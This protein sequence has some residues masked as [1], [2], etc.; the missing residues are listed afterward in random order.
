MPVVVEGA[1]NR[2]TIASALGRRRAVRHEVVV[3]EVHAVGAQVG[4]AVDR[5]DGIERRPDLVAERVTAGVAD[6]PEAEGEV[7]LRAGLVRVRHVSASDGR[8]PVLLLVG[9]LIDPSPGWG[10]GAPRDGRARRGR[11]R[12][13]EQVTPPSST[14]SGVGAVGRPRGAHPPPAAGRRAR[15]RPPGRRRARGVA[16]GLG[17]RPRGAPGAPGLPP[18]DHHRLGPEARP[19]PQRRQQRPARVDAPDAASANRSMKM[20]SAG[21]SASASA[22]S[23]MSMNSAGPQM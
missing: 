16:R 15:R 14:S 11:G 9:P 21:T 1:R 17:A 18:L 13:R 22:S 23:T 2:L 8:S 10:G 6:G 19:R 5:V 7:V 20:R 12:G 3:V 4:E